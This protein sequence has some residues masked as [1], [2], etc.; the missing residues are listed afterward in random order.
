MGLTV[1]TS[2]TLGEAL[3][4]TLPLLQDAQATAALDAGT[5]AGFSVDE[6]LIALALEGWPEGEFAQWH[7]VIGLE[8]TTASDPLR[9]VDLRSATAIALWHLIEERSDD[10]PF[11]AT[12]AALRLWF[13][14]LFP[15]ALADPDKVLALPNTQVQRTLG[16]VLGMMSWRGFRTANELVRG[17]LSSPHKV[18]ELRRGLLLGLAGGLESKVV[19]ALLSALRGSLAERDGWRRA[20]AQTL[21]W[22]HPND[23]GGA[24]VFA[25]SEAL[26]LSSSSQ[27]EVTQCIEGLLTHTAT[28]QEAQGWLL[29]R[30][31][32]WPTQVRAELVTQ[33][34]LAT[35]QE[36]CFSDRSP[37]VLLASIEGFEGRLGGPTLARLRALLHH[38][39]GR[40][41]SAVSIRLAQE[42]AP[43]AVGEAAP[44]DSA[45]IVALPPA[46]LARTTLDRIRSAYVLD[47]P[48]IIPA[49]A[50]AVPPEDVDAARATLRSGLSL[51]DVAA[52]R[53]SVEGLGVLG[54]PED[55]PH[56]LRATR[57]VRG[58]ETLTIAAVR[59][60]GGEVC[61]EELAELFHRR[62]KW[63]DDEAVD[64]FVAIVG[65]ASEAELTNAV[66]T[67]FY[68]PARV[69]AARALA[70]HGFRTS[71]FCLRTRS[72]TDTNEEARLAARQAL[73]AL[74]G[75]DTSAE[76]LAGYE[77][78]HVPIDTL[79]RASERAR[80]AGR[81]AIPGLRYCLAN[82]SWRRR[83]VACEVLGAVPCNEAQGV[84]VEAMQDADED[85]RLAA[86]SAL[87]EQGWTPQDDRTLTLAAIAE[88]KFDR[89]LLNPQRVDTETL[90]QCLR[91]GGHIFRT[92][93]VGLLRQLEEL[94]VWRPPPSLLPAL[95]LAGMDTDGALE[96][97]G[98]M[99]A[100]LT[101][102]DHTW[103]LHPHRAL[104][105]LGL[106]R[107]SA[108]ELA[109]CEASDER[110]WRTREAVCYAMGQLGGH[111]A[112]A[113]LQHRVLDADE[114][115]RLAALD[116]LVHIGTRE[117]AEALATGAQSPFQEDA[118]GVA[119]GLA[120]IGAPALDTVRRLAQSEWWEERR[121][122]AVALLRWRGQPQEAVDIIL[123]LTV[124]CEY[125]VAETARK[126]LLVQGLQPSRDVMH[127]TL[128]QAHPIT[129]SG[130][131][132]W[133]GL[134]VAYR[135]EDSAAAST[136]DAA[137]QATSNESLV[138][139]I[140]LAGR[141]RRYPLRPWLTQLASGAG[142]THVGLRLAATQ[143]VR[144]LDRHECRLCDGR[145]STPCVACAGDGE[146]RC[147][148]CDGE[149]T[150]GTPCP[151]PT[152][153][154]NERM[155][156]IHSVTCKTC[157]GRGTVVRACDCVN[158]FVPCVVCHGGG[159][160]LCLGCN[161]NGKMPSL[162]PE[163]TGASD[164]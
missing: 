63:A 103:Q 60:I 2:S 155:R 35:D 21:P 109:A 49:L 131:E 45:R 154:A 116:A 138:H 43:S 145:G 58:L 91:L 136:F 75:T 31:L 126:T 125:R 150:M 137:L 17:C 36:R 24:E 19:P 162:E 157:R 78:L 37:E 15:L 92:E 93:V 65:A 143:A 94:G 102:V 85:V 47:E 134:D 133:L 10:E 5:M 8:P 38:H 121:A 151:E 130:I 101:A 124:D 141:L 4:A 27:S 7:A 64:H 76:L 146:S 81:K 144:L 128:Q 159:R 95:I 129:L 30:W 67:R 39:S 99:E 100:T 158:G 11:E 149:G 1:A 26:L 161:G 72:L 61:P 110:G 127:Q 40:V 29:E 51:P 119:E 46:T 111:T 41:R 112:I 80:K 139:R 71:I 74:S 98:G 142:T 59:A 32:T 57:L 9:A 66:Q 87:A 122:A 77:V 82:G 147:L 62:L 114:D 105:G 160:S 23:L 14:G 132:P 16:L 152:C 108:K 44:P 163:P 156:A 84:L 68:P 115:V 54:L 140:D 56:L 123:P 13:E 28:Q 52:R 97:S 53:A 34:L 83:V 20:I 106:T 88:R 89:L 55:I 6:R 148:E 50:Q 86:R 153:T 12:L 79:D 90:E 48:E 117:A 18:P 33:G 69:G 113:H 22:T 96:R 42:R 135:F 3:G 73:A 25:L 70:R 164:G 104:L 107:L 120:A 118:H